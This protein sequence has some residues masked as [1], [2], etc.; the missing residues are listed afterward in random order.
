MKK[1]VTCLPAHS[2]LHPAGVQNELE[3]SPFSLSLS[4]SL[5]QAPSVELSLSLSLSIDEVLAYGHTSHATFTSDL[6]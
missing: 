6:V 2:L 3:L 1:P 5:T 4:L